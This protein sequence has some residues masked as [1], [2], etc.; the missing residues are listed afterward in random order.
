VLIEKY[1]HQ[2]LMQEE[3]LLI[4]LILGGLLAANLFLQLIPDHLA[5]N[6]LIVIVPQLIS[7]RFS[8]K[9][10]RSDELLSP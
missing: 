9:A 4:I 10:Q 8:V 3:A 1:S 7:R 5:I 6:S 2:Q